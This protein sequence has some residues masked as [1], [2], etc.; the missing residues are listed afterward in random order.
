MAYLNSN[1]I[2]IYPLAKARQN[3][4]QKWNRLTSEFNMVNIIR[5]LLPKN[6]QGFVIDWAPA[7]NNIKF[8]IGGY[9]VEAN[10]TDI[11][12]S[13]TEISDIY[14]NIKINTDSSLPEIVGQDETAE[15]NNGKYSGISFDNAAI[16]D[17]THLTYSLHLL[18]KPQ[19]SST[20]VI[21]EESKF[22]FG[23][24]SLYITEI[25]GNI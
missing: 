4:D 15:S 16:S 3:A 8:N 14:A 9:Y 12:P 21:P 11:I 13:D 5:Q 10:L 22:P 25:N 18:T 23:S 7:T 1:Y 17:S 19:G 20:W 2:N 24:D 6:S